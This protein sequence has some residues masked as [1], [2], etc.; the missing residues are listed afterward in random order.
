VQQTLVSNG[1][2]ADLAIHNDKILDGLHLPHAHV[3]LTLR[4]VTLDG[5]GQKVRDWNA[6]EHLFVWREAWADLVNQHLHLH[7]H[8][9]KIDHRSLKEQG[10]ELEPQQDRRFCC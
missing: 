2:V 5:F 3:M 6:K 7:S 10:I 4:Q 9:I 8:D 1:M